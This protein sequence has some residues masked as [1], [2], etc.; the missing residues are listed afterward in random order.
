LCSVDSCN[1]LL[2]GWTLQQLCGIFSYFFFFYVCIKIPLKNCLS[3]REPLSPSSS[4][5][6]HLYPGSDGNGQVKVWLFHS[7]KDNFDRRF[8]F[9]DPKEGM[10]LRDCLPNSI[11]YNSPSTGVHTKNMPSQYSKRLCCATQNIQYLLVIW[12]LPRSYTSKIMKST[13]KI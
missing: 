4:L 2:K 9:W 11:M 3:F 1:V 5:G 6:G 13:L 12:P 8:N 7:L 10:M